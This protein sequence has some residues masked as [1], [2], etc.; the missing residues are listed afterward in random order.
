MAMLQMLSK[1]ISAEELLGLVALSEFVHVI[2][3]F[4]PSVPVGRKWELL[5]AISADVGYT[6][7]G[8][9]GVKGRM[10]TRKRSARP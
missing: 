8:W 6:R 2:Q 5:T 9:R 1:M 7:M 10:Y 4:G 3:M